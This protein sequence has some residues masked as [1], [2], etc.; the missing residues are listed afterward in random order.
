MNMKKRT[1]SARELQ[2]QCTELEAENSKLR[3]L[4]AESIKGTEAETR[5]LRI[6]IAAGHLDESQLEAARELA[7]R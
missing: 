7:R 6:L 2:K 1:E 5:V 3:A 4:L